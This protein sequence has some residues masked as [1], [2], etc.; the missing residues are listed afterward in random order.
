[1]TKTELEARLLKEG[2]RKDSYSLDGSTPA[3]DGLVLTEVHGKW[4][5]QYM[6]RGIASPLGEFSSEKE[7][8]Q[9]MYEL[10]SE[11]PTTRQV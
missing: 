3:Y 8:C 2:F 4:S 1:M 7:A 11:D 5:I 6:E 9:R 10:M